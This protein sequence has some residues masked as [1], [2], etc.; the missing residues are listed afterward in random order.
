[1]LTPFSAAH[2]DNLD[3]A[4]HL[5]IALF[6]TKRY[7]DAIPLLDQVS[8]ANDPEHFMVHYY[9]ASYALSQQD[10]DRALDELR[11]FLATRPAEMANDDY[12]I[13]ELIGRAHLLRHHLDEAWKEFES[14]RAARPDL[15]SVQLEMESV[16]ELEGK[17]KEASALIDT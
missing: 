13:H 11:L 17:R 12:S 16:L 15:V 8:R 5:G 4:Y 1:W 14:V 7:A 6:K 2:G 10:G 9:R 3:I